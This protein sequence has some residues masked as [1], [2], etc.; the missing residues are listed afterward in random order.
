MKRVIGFLL[1]VLM[2]ILLIGCG[3]DEN[4]L[5]FY[6]WEGYIPDDILSDFTAETGIKVN[7]TNFSSN[8]EMYSKLKAMNAG[9]F[10]LVIAS[11]YMFQIMAQEG[12]LMKE[13]DKDKISNYKYISESYLGKDF[14]K[15]NKYV[16]PYTTGCILMCYNEK[17]CPI[18]PTGYKSLSDPKL[19]DQVVLLDDMRTM[20]GMMNIMS[21][22]D[23]NE[24]NPEKLENSK[25]ELL[26]IAPNVVA[27]NSDKPH[28]IIASNDASVGLMYNSFVSEAMSLNPDIKVVYPEEGIGIGIDGFFIPQ[29]ADNADN[30][31][32]LI[33]YIMR[34]EV[35]AKIMP[36]IQYGTTNA[37]AVKYLPEEFK[38]NPAINVPEEFTKNS[39]S[40]LDI[41]ESA[42]LYSKIWTEVKLSN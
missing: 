13:L 38:N 21:G 26:K 32:K 12:G 17:T 5:D 1:C 4:S 41:G 36:V 30:A 14:D 24:T 22:Y 16:V 28:E 10:D 6:T 40:I 15:E 29:N 18:V 31:Y 20:I 39:Q 9:E 35:N 37:E 34:P 3:R 7:V 11:D 23:I 27:Y 25:Q 2:L 33:D 8:E 19:K 42:E